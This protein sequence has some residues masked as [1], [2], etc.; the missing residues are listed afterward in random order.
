M[1][2]GA[3]VDKGWT[4]TIA[5]IAT[6]LSDHYTEDGIATFLDSRNRHLDGERP[7]VLCRTKEGRRKVLALA[8][9]IGS[10]G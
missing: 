10:E 5:D 6:V 2:H 3:P 7:I 8:L 1:T 9:L 4:T